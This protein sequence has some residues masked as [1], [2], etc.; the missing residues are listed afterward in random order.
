[1]PISSIQSQASQMMPPETPVE[2]IATSK[3]LNEQ[4]KVAEMTRQFEAVL[5]RQILS[6]SQKSAFKSSVTPDSGVA[7]SI[8]QDMMVNQMA[9]TISSSRTLGMAT[10]LQK[11]FTRQNSAPKSHDSL[12]QTISKTDAPKK[13]APPVPLTKAPRL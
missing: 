1:M 7:G 10:E 5:L 4:Q 6:Q 13:N 12:Q 2:K 11:Q 8:Y 9:E 3:T